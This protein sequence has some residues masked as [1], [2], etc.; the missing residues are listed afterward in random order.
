[1]VGGSGCLAGPESG[2][3]SAK[4]VQSYCRT[5]WMHSVSDLNVIIFGSRLRPER[6]C[7]LAHCKNRVSDTF[8]GDDALSPFVAVVDVIAYTVQL[9]AVGF[10][11]LDVVV[12]IFHVEVMIVLGGQR[13]SDLFRTQ[14]QREPRVVQS[15]LLGL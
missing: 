8:S 2:Q 4:T 13:S 5:P 9:D 6:L 11:N 3:L 7:H 15:H 12:A 14:L 1:M 10:S